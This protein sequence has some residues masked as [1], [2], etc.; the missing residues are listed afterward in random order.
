ME[1]GGLE[2][3]TDNERIIFCLNFSKLD[4]PNLYHMNYTDFTKYPLIV[5]ILLTVACASK[6][7]KASAS[8]EKNW[9]EM[10][11][12]HMVMAETF[13]PYKDSANLEPAKSRAEELVASAEKWASSPIPEKVNNSEMK[14]KLET[15]KKESSILVSKVSEADDKAIAAQLTKVHDLFHTIQEEWYGGGEAHEHH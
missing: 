12:F 5:L 2:D 3:E 11:D 9:K 7:D 6:M 10:D 14:D 8:E 4:C 15:L 13:H 1:T